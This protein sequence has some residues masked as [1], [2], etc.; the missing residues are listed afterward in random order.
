[1]N[2][3]IKKTSFLVNY[4]PY[5][6]WFYYT[7]V[8]FLFKY[9]SSF[10]YHEY[11]NSKYK[12]AIQIILKQLKKEYIIQN[13]QT[14]PT[15]ELLY[16]FYYKCLREVFKIDFIKFRIQ[17]RIYFKGNYI[18]GYINCCKS[19][20]KQ[21]RQKEEMILHEIS[22]FFQIDIDILYLIFEKE[23]NFRKIK[24]KY[25]SSRKDII[26]P[27]NLD[28]KKMEYIIQFLFKKFKFYFDK[29]K[30]E[31]PDLKENLIQIISENYSFDS[32]YYE[33]NGIE[34]EII[35]KFLYQNNLQIVEID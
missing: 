17:R 28:R 12:K 9:S 6:N 7:S 14:I 26:I 8:F 22:D 5:S 10:F 24:G 25:F 31:N 23:V 33:Y 30:K 11:L 13:D 32:V 1:M 4:L 18:Y 15:L 16:F 34:Y 20:I 19:F 27:I 21:L 29:F 3:I 2:S 35:E